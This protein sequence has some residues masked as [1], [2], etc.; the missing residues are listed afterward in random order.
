MN[1]VTKS[2][3]DQKQNKKKTKES[4]AFLPINASV[5]EGDLETEKFDNGE[6]P[7]EREGITLLKCL[8]KAC[9]KRK[10]E[11]AKSNPIIYYQSKVILEEER[12]KSGEP[13]EA[14]EEVKQKPS[15]EEEKDDG[16]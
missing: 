1:T 11:E 4:D 15:E 10:L 16:G 13:V 12:K 3:Q 6:R 14:I 7:T 5:A 2:V 8:L 9:K